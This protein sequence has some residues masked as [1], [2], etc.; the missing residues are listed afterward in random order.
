LAV[1][2]TSLPN[3]VLSEAYTATV[4]ATGGTPPY[5]FSISGGTFPT[6]GTLDPSTGAIT[7]TPDATGTSPFTVMVTDSSTPTAQTATRALNL[8]INPAAAAC[9]SSGNEAVL[10]GQ[11]A[12]SLSGFTGTGF[13]AVVGSFTADG[14]GAITTGEA[15][16]NGVLG[17]QTGNLITA[18]SSH[19]VGSDNRGCATLAT[20]F[21]TF[22]TRFALGSLSSGVATEG[23]L[24][25]WEA[26]TSSAYIAAG[27]ILQQT[28]SSFSG[29]YAFKQTGADNGRRVGGVG[30]VSASSGSFTD[31]ELDIN[32][33]GNAAHIAGMTGTYTSADA[34]GRFTIATLWTGMSS[35]SHA[36]MYMVSS[37]QSLLMTTD[38]PTSN[39]VMAGEIQQQTGT[40]SNSSVNGYMVFYMT[41]LPYNGPPGARVEFGLLNANGTSSLT[42][43]DY[44]DEAGAWDTPNPA[45]VTC[46]YSVASNG[47]M[48]LGGASC[49][50]GTAVYLTAANQGF[51]LNG[52]P[53]VGLGHIEPQVGRPFSASSFSGA[54][55]FGTIEPVNQA[56]QTYVGLVTLDGS[57]GYSS[58]ADEASTTQQRAGHSDSGTVTVNSDGTL[59]ASG[60][61][62]GVII[63]SAEFF[64]L[65]NITDTYP[66]MY[67]GKQ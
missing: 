25:Q 48:T 35:P 67:L 46:T 63:S 53:G 26:P 62:A 60:L 42:A 61:V 5:S 55:Y 64:A 57:G 56:E 22:I 52:D 39:A 31:G 40:F 15:D 14:T 36:V 54:M 10:T 2:S 1:I 24:I 23:R 13:L 29:S 58:I 45:T 65:D 34:D 49:G 21:G 4:A 9:T 18:A 66:I 38:D 41:G 8:T 6:W 47:R 17:A 51:M 3:G 32:D 43:T 50:G 16:T 19:S 20:P 12:F 11:Y 28:A 7:G 27:H 59:S 44:D 37:S 30:V 33:G